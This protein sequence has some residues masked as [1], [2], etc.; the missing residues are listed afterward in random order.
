MVVCLDTHILIWGIQGEAL[1]EFSSMVAMTQEFLK[2]LDKEGVK[3]IVPAPV[4]WEFLMG[5]DMDR[6]KSALEV[7]HKRFRII[8]FDAR[9]AFAAN[10]IWQK[11]NE[12]KKL[13]GE[14]WHSFSGGKNKAKIDCQIIAIARVSGASIIYSHD[15]DMEKLA[16][17]FVEVREV[18]ML[19]VQ[20]ELGL[21][22]SI[23]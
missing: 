16:Q 21:R 12:E 2:K 22:I 13:S 15:G 17:G 14:D 11:N 6:A 19:P 20:T 8:P 5:I 3:A 1:P 10:E 9:A 18:P 4:V 23:E 7:L